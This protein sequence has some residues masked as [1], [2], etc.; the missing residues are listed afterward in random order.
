MNKIYFPGQQMHYIYIQI[1]TG[2]KVNILVGYSISHS[3]QTYLYEHV[4][5]SEQFPR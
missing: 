3:K 5:Y 1:V 4:S 2:R